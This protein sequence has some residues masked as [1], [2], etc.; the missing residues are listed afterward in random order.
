[1][2]LVSITACQPHEGRRAQALLSAFPHAAGMAARAASTD[3]ATATHGK[4]VLRHPVFTRFGDVLFRPA[5][6]DAAPVMIF[7]LGGSMA[8][9]TLRSLQ[10]EFGIEAGS[11]DGWM[12]ALVVQSLDFVA[13]IRPGDPFPLEVLGG[14][15]SWQPGALHQR[16]AEE[17][18]RLQL[19]G[20]FSGAACPAWASEDPHAV[21][22]AAAEPGM[23]ERLQSAAVAAAAVLDLR[24]AAAAS[25]LLATAA[26]EMGFIEALRDRLLRRVGRMLARVDMLGAGVGH[27]LGAMELLSRVRR[28]AGI[29]YDK[30]RA[31]FHELESC[32]AQVTGVLRDLDGWTSTVRPHRDWLYS[33]LRAWEGLLT[34]WEGGGSIWSQDTWNLLRRTYRFLAP[35]FMPVQEWHFANH[36]QRVDAALREPMVW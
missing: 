28:L 13:E 24:N 31:R 2:E 32:T 7:S 11:P 18:L 27:N 16:V 5:E 10:Q 30:L 34:A 21:L 19:V 3:P 8:A 17:R 9:I 23:D 33:S 26:Y 35:R 20:A 36:A 6:A 1:M 12:L 25:R 4:C 22:L 29:A 15:A 14:G